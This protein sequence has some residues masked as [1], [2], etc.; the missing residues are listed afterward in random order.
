MLLTNTGF[1]IEMRNVLKWSQNYIGF[2]MSIYYFK[3]KSP[4]LHEM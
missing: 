3:T 4:A 1:T 2:Y